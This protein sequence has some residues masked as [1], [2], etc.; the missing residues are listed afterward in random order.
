MKQS[1]KLH[2]GSWWGKESGLPLKMHV[3]MLDCKACFEKNAE[4]CFEN[5][6]NI[7]APRLHLENVHFHQ[8]ILMTVLLFLLCECSIRKYL[9]GS[10]Y[11]SGKPSYCCIP[12]NL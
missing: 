12:T 6:E 3:K 10:V 1:Q 4:K 8:L 5:L 2:F 9:A 7:A 11:N